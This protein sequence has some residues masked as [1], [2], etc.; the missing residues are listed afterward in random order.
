MLGCM[1]SPLFRQ[2]VLPSILNGLRLLHGFAW[3]LIVLGEMTGMQQSLGAVILN[4][5]MF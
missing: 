1:G 2:V 3:I 5:R 4:A